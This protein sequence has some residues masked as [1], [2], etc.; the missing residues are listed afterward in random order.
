MAPCIPCSAEGLGAVE[1]LR[2]HAR[3][4]HQDHDVSGVPDHLGTPLH[5]KVR[6]RDIPDDQ[7]AAPGT[8]TVPVLELL[9]VLC[10][11]QLQVDGLWILGDNCLN[12]RIHEGMNA[13]ADGP[14]L[15]GFRQEFR[16]DFA[17]VCK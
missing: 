14:G 16:Q 12:P 10:E 5:E 3:H 1:R 11:Q 17:P 8:G 7:L 6:V 4:E 9:A 13:P 15:L 2:R